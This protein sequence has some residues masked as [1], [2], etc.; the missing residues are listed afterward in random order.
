[1][2]FTVFN[3]KQLVF[4]SICVRNFKMRGKLRFISI[5]A[6]DSDPTFSFLLS[7][8]LKRLTACQNV[9]VIGLTFSF[10]A[11]TCK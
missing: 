11:F 8:S 2:V 1:M 9:D 10:E 3:C 4:R 6:C 5:F 7:Y